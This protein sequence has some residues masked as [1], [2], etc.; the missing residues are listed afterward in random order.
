MERMSERVLLILREY[1][2]F[3]IRRRRKNRDTTIK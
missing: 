1:V 2:G 3:S